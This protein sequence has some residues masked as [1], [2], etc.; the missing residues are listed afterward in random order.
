[1]L[2]AFENNLQVDFWSGI[3]K[4]GHVTTAMVA[5]EAQEI[6]TKI[7]RENNIYFDVTIDDVES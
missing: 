1:M 5:P 4:A 6:F 3:R 2:L 7:L